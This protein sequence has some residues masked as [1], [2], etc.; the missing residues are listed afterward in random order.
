[1]N[2]AQYLERNALEW[3]D[4]PYLSYNG[5][6]YTFSQFAADVQAA[7]GYL[8]AN[9]GRGSRTAIFAEN[10]YEWAV[11]Y[12]A[13]IAYSG[14]CM[15]IDK[16]WVEH[17]LKNTFGHICPDAL[18]YS[19]KTAD[20]AKSIKAEF[21]GIRLIPIEDVLAGAQ[22]YSSTVVVPR[23]DMN[24]TAIIFF[25]SGTTGRPKAIPL[26]QGNMLA[27]VET[28]LER[29]P[30]DNSDLS[31]LFLPL[32]H[33]YA[34]IS[35]FLYSLVSGIRVHIC[36]DVKESIADMMRLRPTA[37]CTVPLLLK[38]MKEGMTPQLM[39]ML[40]NIKWLYCGGSGLDVGLKRWYRE[41]GVML[42]D[43]YGSTETSAIV[44]TDIPGDFDDESCGKVFGGVDIRIKDPDEEGF[45]EILI[46]GKN[47]TSGYIGYD[48]NDRYFDSEGF[49]HSG[50][51]GRVGENGR[52][53]IK[54]RIKRLL[55]L[56]NSKNV[57]ADELE[58]LIAAETGA[59][60]V[61]VYLEEG[62][63]TAQ[64]FTDDDEGVCGKIDKVN[65]LLPH[66]KQ[67]K[68]VHISKAEGRMLK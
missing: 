59:K 62:E 51:I 29:T 49:Y 38:R 32:S 55:D 28:L 44:A 50:D 7:A 43:T 42:L 56:P 68:R 22:E 21:P 5:E 2:I 9:A 48:E 58:E 15:P 14:V 53:Y 64:I 23:T 36:S 24:E 54:G 46:R 41:R 66:F 52:L 19:Q 8:C 6:E 1:M 39:D 3:A 17:D 40:K 37:V 45:G 34:G 67:I 10:S 33:V 61:R 31:V 57:Y 13:V 20:R 26:T 27:N 30:M 16:E 4:K 11:M 12:A 25:S 65:T 35:N 47:V 63:I 18:I 60:K